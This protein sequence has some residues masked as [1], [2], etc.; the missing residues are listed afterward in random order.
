MEAKPNIGAIRFRLRVIHPKARLLKREGRKVARGANQG[1]VADP[2]G[3]FQMSM[4][5]Q[6]PS[7]ISALVVL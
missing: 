7:G 2:M 5:P 3:S 4:L 1:S 6:S